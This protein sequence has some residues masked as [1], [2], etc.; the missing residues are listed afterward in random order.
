L[1]QSDQIRKW[2]D[3]RLELIRG[4]GSGG[5]VLFWL[6]GIAFSL[7]VFGA[8]TSGASSSTGFGLATSIGVLIWAVFEHDKKISAE[9][10]IR[11]LD[12]YLELARK[13]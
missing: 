9:R 6:G 12:T 11:V 7:C 13:R 10:K 8:W 5:T 1:E 3:E 4:S 2:E